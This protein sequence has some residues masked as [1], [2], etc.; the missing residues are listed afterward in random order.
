MTC[1]LLPSRLTSAAALLTIVALLFPPFGI[2]ATFTTPSQLETM[3]YLEALKNDGVEDAGDPPANGKIEPTQW[4]YLGHRFIFAEP[5]HFIPPF[6]KGMGGQVQMLS[7]G[8]GP[9]LVQVAVIWLG[10]IAICG[11]KRRRPE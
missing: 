10:M 5:R 11:L 6:D 3:V 2:V 8:W 7:V 9:L 1:I 4:T